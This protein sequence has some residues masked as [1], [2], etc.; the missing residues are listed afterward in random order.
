M[1]HNITKK[2]RVDLKEIKTWQICCV[3]VQDKG[4]KFVV[5]SKDEYC[6]KVSTQISLFIQ[7]PH[8]KTKSNMKQYVDSALL[9]LSSKYIRV[10]L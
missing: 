3:R 5:I 8:D 2:E 7:L 6:D 9:C 4:S 1:F 10:M